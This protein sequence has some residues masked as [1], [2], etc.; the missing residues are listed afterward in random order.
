MV[1]SAESMKFDSSVC[2]GVILNFHQPQKERCQLSH[3]ITTGIK[4]GSHR[5]CGLKM[6]FRRGFGVL[7]LVFFKLKD[8][9]KVFSISLACK[10]Y[11]Q[12]IVYNRCWY[13]WG[14]KAGYNVSAEIIRWKKILVI[15]IGKG[16]NSK[17]TGYR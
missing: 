16:T 12:S 6:K 17:S 8:F 5:I 2:L 15:N 4:S 10:N 7:L 3:S 14:K 11:F 1:S 13:F 9:I